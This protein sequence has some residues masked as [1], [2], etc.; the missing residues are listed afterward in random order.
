MVGNGRVESA[1][2]SVGVESQGTDTGNMGATATDFCAARRNETESLRA[3]LVGMVL[4]LEVL[5]NMLLRLLDESAD[6]V[7]GMDM[8]V[9]ERVWGRLRV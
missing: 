6:T 1:L 4:L 9:D 3:L 8:L 5:Y 7:T 2:G